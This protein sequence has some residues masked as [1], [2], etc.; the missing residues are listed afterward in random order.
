MALYEEV[1]RSKVLISNKGH[2]K[3]QIVY[4]VLEGPQVAYGG[5]KLTTTER[6]FGNGFNWS[7]L[8]IH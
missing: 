3:M 6:E 5:I 1:E 7:T 4:N 8:Y 2:F